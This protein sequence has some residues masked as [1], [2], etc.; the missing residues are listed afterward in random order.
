LNYYLLAP[1]ICLAGFAVAVILLDLFI[2]RKGILA[3]IGIT[4]LV[5]CLGI[6][7]A[8][9]GREDNTLFNGMLIVDELAIFFKPLFC[10]VA[11][12]VILASKDYVFKFPRFQGEYYALILLSVIG[13]MLMAAARELISIYIALELTGL[14]LYALVGFLKDPKSSEAGLKYLLL[15]AIASAI[16]LYGMALI[17]GLTGQT[18][19]WDIAYSLPLGRVVDSPALLL[20][21]VFLIAGFGFKIATIPFQMWVPDVYEGAPTPITAY[22]SVASKAA[23]F[24]VILRVFLEAFGGEVLLD[25]AIIFAVLSAISMTLGNVVAIGQANIKRMLGYSSIAQAGYLMVGLAAVTEAT[26]AADFGP[27]GLIFFIACY[28]A[29]NLGAFIAIIAISNKIG[30]DSIDD[31]SG[32]GRRAPLLSL[33]L[34]FCLVSLTG[35]PPTA[36]FLAKFYLFNAAVHHGLAWLVIIAVINT[37][38]S[39]YYYFRVI[40][41]TWFGTPVSEEGIPSSWA[42]R[43]ALSIACLGVLVL[44]FLPS[45]LLDVAQTV[46]GTLFP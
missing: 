5:A 38:I 17:F 42:L 19:L 11:I 2:P 14:S 41:V 21:L 35:L 23:G 9:W 29:A 16:L 3:A 1:E 32:V 22:L 18:R 37:A 15:G 43:A 13:M 28:A 27:T 46:A 33:A 12:L 26:E 4:G 44:F 24:A 20:G 8:L 31:Y 7:I 39:A 25:W 36:G 45:P 40:K 30:S 10:G 34:T 6:S